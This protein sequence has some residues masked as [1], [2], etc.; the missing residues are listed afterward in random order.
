MKDESAGPEWFLSYSDKVNIAAWR[1]PDC[2]KRRN[3]T[4]TTIVLS[5]FWDWVAS[6]VPRTV[7]PNI[8]T[9]AGF[10]CTLQAY[11]LVYFHMDQNPQI[12]S[13]TAMMLIF[14]YM[15]LN[16][17]D[18]IH[19]RRVRNVSP[20]GDLFRKSCDNIGCVFLTLTLL[21][22]LGIT[23][24]ATAWYIVQTTQMFFM[25][26][27][28]RA[29][30]QPSGELIHGIFS[31]PGEALALLMA[32]LGVRATFGLS[33]IYKTY[34]HV[35][36]SYIIP[37]V[38][39]YFVHTRVWDEGDPDA[40]GRDTVKWF[41]Y[42][43]A[44]I[45]V[46][47]ALALG[48]ERSRFSL[49]ICICY[50]LI[51]AVFIWI[52]GS[53]FSSSYT[54]LK[55]VIC[56][57]LFLSV[58]TTDIVVAKRARRRIHPW[59]ILMCMASI[60]NYF[61]SLGLV[62]FYY[63]TIL[64][65]LSLYMNLPLLTLTTN[66]YCD[67]V[68]DLCHKGHKNLF[69]AALTFGNRLLVGVMSDEDCEQYK[70][71]PIMTTDERCKEVNSCKAVHKAIPLPHDYSKTGLTREFIEEHNIHIVAHGAEYNLDNEAYAKKI[72]EGA[73]IDYYKVP[74]EMGITRTFPR[75]E[76]IST[77][78]LIKRIVS[79]ADEFT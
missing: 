55:S 22:V 50:R 1:G 5:P 4:I 58:L 12:V 24:G 17:I 3:K 27:Q 19:A 74:R 76:G 10:T 34:V 78:D 75:T 53:S 14:A 52:S 77:S 61:I 49:L 70:R 32:I 38:V 46:M 16:S 25:I 31:G 20:V 62:M 9:L 64:A 51:P 15:T 30:M 69:Q 11:Y 65:E 57:G 36:N 63:V 73:C 37:Y 41:Y 59:V 8:L 35:M 13:F 66:V 39:N 43:I 28:M 72:A 48:K 29:W 6:L 40:I 47:T 68:Y 54:D 67:G 60:F 79:R 2:N 45:V 44:G 71:R 21:S 26:E 23:E 18:G 7:A 33:W 42:L 56:D